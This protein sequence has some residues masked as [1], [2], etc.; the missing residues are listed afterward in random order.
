MKTLILTTAA[1]ALSAVVIAPASAQ[2]YGNRPI[3]QPGSVECQQ[4]ANNSRLVGGLVGAGIGALAGRSV[5]ARG[6]RS[7]GGALG[8][9]AGAIAGSEIGR[10]NVACNDARFDPNRRDGNY[11]NNGYGYQRQPVQNNGYYDN[12]SYNRG[13]YNNVGYNDG[14]YNHGGYQAPQ[15]ACGWGETQVR[16]PNGRVTNQQ[17]WMCQAS[18]GNWYPAQ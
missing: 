4:S 13:G 17:V 3:P 18:D 16:S 12:G 9:V 8:A 10:R 11:S 5:A 14:R 6:N 15:P 7:E 2:S 1:I